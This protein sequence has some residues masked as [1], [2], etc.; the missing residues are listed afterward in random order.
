MHN[1]DKSQM[2]YANERCQIKKDRYILHR[3]IYMTFRKS[4]ST[5]IKNGSVV[6][7]S[8]G[9]GEGFNHKRVMRR[10]LGRNG[11]SGS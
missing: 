5:G 3:A 4:K 10:N 7:K 6:L 2:R 1:V 8:G 11:G 9:R